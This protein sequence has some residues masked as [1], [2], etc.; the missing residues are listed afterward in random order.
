[1]KMKQAG[2]GGLLVLGLA[3][4]ASVELEALGVKSVPRGDEV[5][6]QGLVRNAGG[7]DAQGPVELILGSTPQSFGP[8]ITVMSTTVWN[9]VIGKNGQVIETGAYA[10][11][12][13]VAGGVYWVELLVD[14]ENKIKEIT[15]S[16][17]KFNDRNFKP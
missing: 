10:C 12:P 15:K 8:K 6:F 11:Q 13:M 7:I 17:N 2:L 14:P 5:C 16:N 4:C 1:M 9:G 3:G